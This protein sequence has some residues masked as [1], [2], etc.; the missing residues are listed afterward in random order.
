MYRVSDIAA[1]LHQWAPPALAW[2]KDNV[3]LQIGNPFNEVHRIFVS[4]DITSDVV[5]EAIDRK[6][7]LIVAHHPLIFRPLKTIREDSDQGSMIRKLVKN[8]ISVVAIHTN[9]DTAKYGLNYHLAE[10]LGL[11]DIQPLNAMTHLYKKIYFYHTVDKKTTAAVSNYLD[12]LESVHWVS[13]E[14]E[15]HTYGFEIELPRWYEK[16]IVQRLRTLVNGKYITFHSVDLEKESS[17]YGIGAFGD[18]HSPTT[19]TSF[20]GT[21]KEKLRAERIRTNARDERMIGRVAVCGGS[22]AQFLRDAERVGADMFITSDL[23]YHTFFDSRDKIILV[24]AGHYE[25]EAVF[26]DACVKIM[27]EKTAIDTTGLE[28]FPVQTNTN[29]I[30]FL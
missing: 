3:G 26:I 12:T 18:L 8:D 5:H 25:T 28:I 1:I 9:A 24:D 11:R 20:L 14:V 21:V 10:L 22:G 2:E 15:A 23:T 13:K 19:S 16:D 4:L 29:P 7:D 30:R 6:I 17:D 27:K